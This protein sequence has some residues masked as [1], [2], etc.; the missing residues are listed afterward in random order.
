MSRWQEDERR[1]ET[2]LL[3]A[4]AESRLAWAQIL[5]DMEEMKQAQDDIIYLRKKLRVTV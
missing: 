5:R 3:I 1:T 4:E 2:E